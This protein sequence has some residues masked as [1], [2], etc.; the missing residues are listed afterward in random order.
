[1]KK[2]FIPFFLLFFFL[3]A[4]LGLL[5]FSIY[6]NNQTTLPL[7]FVTKKTLSPTPQPFFSLTLSPDNPTLIANQINTLKVIL[8][9]QK[10]QNQQP[11]TVQ[12]EIA[13]DPNALHQ[14]KLLPGTYFGAPKL[15]LSSINEK[16]GRIS[17]ALSGT[18]TMLSGIAATI[19][20]VPNPAFSGKETSVY[21]LPKSM[22][23]GIAEENL[24]NATY[25]TKLFVATPSALGN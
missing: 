20:F 10:P 9:T 15:L 16:T 25:G 6:T 2:F 8:E 1:M 19:T 22:I 18:A 12:F 4:G 3:S 14:I 21:F 17:Y 23:R 7:M 11:Q 24:L 13:Y 5:V